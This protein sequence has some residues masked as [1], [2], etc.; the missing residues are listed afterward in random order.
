MTGRHRQECRTPLLGEHR[1]PRN[2]D[3]RT[4][5]NRPTGCRHDWTP[6]AAL[7]PRSKTV[8]SPQWEGR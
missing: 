4:E 5:R 7:M 2:R 8:A 1:M 3:V 6:V